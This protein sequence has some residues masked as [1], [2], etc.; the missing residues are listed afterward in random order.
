MFCYQM[1]SK[2]V[3]QWLKGPLWC[4]CGSHMLCEGNV[5]HLEVSEGGLVQRIV[6]TEDLLPIF[7]CDLW[8][9]NWHALNASCPLP[10]KWRGETREIFQ[11]APQSPR[12]SQ[13]TS[14][15]SLERKKN[16]IVGQCCFLVYI[17]ITQKISSEEKMLYLP[18]MI[19]T[20]SAAIQLQPFD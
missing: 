14:W 19:S 15:N 13:C 7:L 9:K 3:G 8:R 18:Y 1:T 20:V 16:E 11:A 17:C 5:F 12:I 10:I 6:E 4:N 2:N